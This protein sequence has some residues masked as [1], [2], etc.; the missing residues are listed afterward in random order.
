M[1]KVKEAWQPADRIRPI[2]YALKNYAMLA[3]VLIKVRYE[4]ETY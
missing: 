1:L 2:S 3:P 4:T